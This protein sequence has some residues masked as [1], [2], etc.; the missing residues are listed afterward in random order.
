MITRLFVI[1]H[2]FSQSNAGLYKKEKEI[3]MSTQVFDVVVIGLGPVGLTMAATLAQLNRKVAVIERHAGLYGMPRAGHI[4]HEIV[5]LLQSLKAEGPVLNDSYPTLEYVWKNQHGETLL[6]FDWGAEGVSGFHSDYMQYQPILE[7]A[8]FSAISNHPNVTMFRGWEA[9]EF[10]EGPD[11]IDVTLFKTEVKPGQTFPVR[12]EH[13]ETIRGRYLAGADGANSVV[14]RWMGIERDDLGFN[15]KWLDVDARK[16]RDFQLDFDCGQI[17]DPARPVTI[18]PLGKRHRRW[19]WAMMPGETKEQLEKPETAWKLLAE[20]GVTQDDVEIVRQIVYTFEAR[21]AKQWRKGRAFLIGDAA[22]TMPPFQ[23]QGMCSGMRDAKNLAWKF[24]YVLRGIASP[25]LLDTYQEERYPHVYDWTV[26]S[27]ESGKIPCTFDS[28]AA[29]E[30][31][32]KFRA[33]WRPPMPD[34]PQLKTGVLGRNAAG[35]L[36]PL[37]GQLG[38][39]ARVRKDGREALFDD[40]IPNHG[41]VVIS[42]IDDPRKFLSADHA[43]LL[44]QLGTTFAYVGPQGSTSDVVDVNGS[45]GTYFKKHGIEV[46]V[47]RPDF[48]VFAGAALAD[49]PALF[50]NLKAQ[51]R[52]ID[53]SASQ[54]GQPPLI[55]DGECGPVRSFSSG[56]GTHIQVA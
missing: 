33:G 23:G 35:D 54:G 41:Y 29:E 2:G 46:L 32:A 18:L 44:A 47:V 21:I 10:T 16:K 38:L 1:A 4:D 6:D 14:R 42:T 9:G 27:I 37:A 51:L 43:A 49:L 56:P 3:K 34:F 19:E 7:D 55:A 53:S 30:R 22:H 17:C 28:K 45:Y 24:D 36:L 26:I 50:D 15:E 48:Y 31:D 52:L 13:S 12:T 39:Q 40:L 20:Q 8:L 25:D 5:R 11:C